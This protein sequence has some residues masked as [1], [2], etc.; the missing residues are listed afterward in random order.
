[1]GVAGEDDLIELFRLPLDRLHDRRVT[2]A[3]RHHPPRSDR[4]DDAAAIGGVQIRTLA[5]CDL[6]HIG[7]QRV[8][9]DL[10]GRLAD[11]RQVLGLIDIVTH[12][13]AEPLKEA[14][15]FSN[16]GYASTTIQPLKSA[17]IAQEGQIVAIVLAETFEAA[18]EASHRVKVNYT[19]ATPSTTFDS[20]GVTSAHAKGQLAQ[21]TEDPKVG[22]FAKAFG[23]AEVKISAAYQTPPQHHNPMELFATSCV[24][25]GDSL[26][27]YEPSQYVHGLKNGVAEQLD[28]D[29]DNDAGPLVIHG[30]G[31]SGGPGGRGAGGRGGE[32]GGAAPAAP[33]QA[34]L[35]AFDKQT[36]KQVG[37]V[38]I[39]AVFGV[40]ISATFLH[41]G[42]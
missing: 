25:Y 9:R 23:E 1:M 34:Q 21:F 26:T 14:K 32:R 2:M 29:A 42:Q 31:R 5:A 24:W 8:L 10:G 20:P 27:V 28:I 36:G 3:V 35:Y 40:A 38:S 13:N 22:D 33:A 12:E 7:L 11:A 6:D 18:R 17:E 37:A 4:I 30:T 19:A 39:P 16:G 15:L 41:S